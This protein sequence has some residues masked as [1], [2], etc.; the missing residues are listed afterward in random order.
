MYMPS[1]RAC[2]HVR[3]LSG[4]ALLTKRSALLVF[5]GYATVRPSWHRQDLDCT[6]DWQ[7]AQRQGA[8]GVLTLIVVLVLTYLSVTVTVIGSAKQSKPTRE[9]G[10]H[11]SC[12][13]LMF[14]LRL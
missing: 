4:A 9:P 13:D 11:G 3:A 14:G 6:A 1:W 2:S 8:Q 10:A 7:D 12:C 5:A